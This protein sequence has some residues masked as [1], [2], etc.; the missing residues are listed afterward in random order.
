MSS[1]NIASASIITEGWSAATDIPASRRD[2]RSSG[3]YESPLSSGSSTSSSSL[4]KRLFTAKLTSRL[5]LCWEE[6][7]FKT[8][9]FHSTQG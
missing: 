7:S 2:M 4:D 3:T 8:N 1:E 5:V 9:K 6:S